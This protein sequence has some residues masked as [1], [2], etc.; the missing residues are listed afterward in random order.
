MEALTRKRFKQLI[1]RIESDNHANNVLGE[2][3]TY[4]PDKQQRLYQT[5]GE[6]ADFLKKIN[7]FTVD[8]QVGQR[9]G[10]GVGKPI[11]YRVDT[12][13]NERESRYVG[14]LIG[15]EYHCQ[16]TNYD[17]H[18]RYSLMDSWAHVDDFSL[19]YTVQV[20]QQVARDS[21]MIGWCGERA[22]NNTDL[23]KNPSLQDVNEGW[24]AKVRRYQPQRFM[25]YDSTG[26][27]TNDAYKLGEG[28]D[29]LTLDELVFDMVANLMDEWH[30]EADDLVVM[31]GRD[32][33]VNHGMALLSNSA[34]PTERN[35]LSTWFADKTVAGYSCIKP[36]FLPRRA[37]VVTSY[38]NLSLYHQLGSLRRT[39]VDNPKRDRVE[40]YLSQN[41]AYVIEDYGKFAAVRDGAIQL[42]N[43][44]GEWV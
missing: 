30:Q 39:I 18:L 17:T 21:L 10:L 36:P 25:G 35:A 2:K 20:T 12:E 40:E 38:N 44:A 41:E 7:Q 24:L 32:I 28:G 9:I 8:A 19:L 37:V 31:V 42:K 34:L 5:L 4:E 11:A 33:W 22:A 43:R 16:Q 15:D 13:E 27:V 6:S 29:Y 14:D 26:K 23:A 1:S 3:F